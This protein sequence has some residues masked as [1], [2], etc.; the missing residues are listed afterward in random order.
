[1]IM[2]FFFLSLMK[3]LFWKS[4]ASKR[5]HFCRSQIW[6]SHPNVPGLDEGLE[7]GYCAYPQTPLSISPLFISVVGHTAVH[8]IG[9]VPTLY[10]RNRHLCLYLLKCSFFSPFGFI[11][12]AVGLHVFG[13]DVSARD[14]WCDYAVCFCYL[15][16]FLSTELLWKETS[17]SWLS[18]VRKDNGYRQIGCN[19][20]SCCMI[21]FSA[22]LS[23]WDKLVLTFPPKNPR[24]FEICNLEF[25]SNYNSLNC[26]R[27]DPV[28]YKD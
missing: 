12:H 23:R 17:P 27:E 14:C 5:G 9:V 26:V 20:I 28:W 15:K 25:L 18:I 8:E 24:N 11:F 16:W 10:W 4:V 7:V 19:T 6:E 1:M 2:I 21:V 3:C 22:V 13:G